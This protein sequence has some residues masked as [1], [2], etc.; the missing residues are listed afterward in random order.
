MTKPDRDDWEAMG[1]TEEEWLLKLARL[2][3]RRI[4]IIKRVVAAMCV[5]FLLSLFKFS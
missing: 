4:L 5:A 3:A 1:Y 2:R